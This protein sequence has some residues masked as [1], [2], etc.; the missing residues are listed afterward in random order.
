MRAT[1][2]MVRFSKVMHQQREVHPTIV[3][4]LEGIVDQVNNDFVNYL[5]YKYPY[6]KVR[7]KVN[8]L[9]KKSIYQIFNFFNC[10]NENLSTDCFK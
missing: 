2:A 7:I 1:P 8:Q 4:T 3:L 5:I 9:T 6:F 10:K